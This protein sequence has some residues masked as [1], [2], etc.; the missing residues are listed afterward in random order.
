MCIRDRGNT[1][2][3]AG[4]PKVTLT[5]DGVD[6]VEQS[7]QIGHNTHATKTCLL[8]TSHVVAGSHCVPPYVTFQLLSLYTRIVFT[9][10]S[11]S[12]VM[13]FSR[14][15]SSENVLIKK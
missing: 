6:S 10:A 7:Y 3:N 14:K 12:N 11:R 9:P 1:W 2:N 4:S 8:Y 15:V 5:A 13:V